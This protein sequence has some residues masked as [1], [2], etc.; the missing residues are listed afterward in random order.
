MS[1]YSRYVSRGQT[2]T[3]AVPPAEL[4]RLD[5]PVRIRGE[6]KVQRDDLGQIIMNDNGV[7]VRDFP[8]LPITITPD[9]PALHVECWMRRHPDLRYVDLEARF[10][11][12]TPRWTRNERNALNNRRRREV[13]D[14]YGLR[15]WSGRYETRPTQVL[16]DAVSK[17]SDEQIA[18]NTSWVVTPTHIHPPGFPSHRIPRQAYL[19]DGEIIHTAS[20]EIQN[21]KALIAKLNAKARGQGKSSWRELEEKDLPRE[22]FVRPGKRK[23]VAENLEE[24]RE[25]PSTAFQGAVKAEEN[26]DSLEFEE[27]KP[28]DGNKKRRLIAPSRLAKRATM[29][30]IPASSRIFRSELQ[31][32]RQ[33]TIRANML[34]YGLI[35]P[36]SRIPEYVVSVESS[37]LT[38]TRL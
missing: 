13:R 37:T 3:P 21:A 31:R 33:T 27:I 38:P 22:W 1:S 11:P 30:Q 20:K 26:K 7:V 9:V 24:E 16:L 14:R 17:L 8:G 4:G 35:Y 2:S 12:G 10:P 36:D 29:K 25:D 19:D 28:F 5:P 15:D 34:K 32:Q 6:T 18:L 23:R